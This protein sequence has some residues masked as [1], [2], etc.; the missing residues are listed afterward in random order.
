MTVQLPA[1]LIGNAEVAASSANLGPGFDSLGLA[2]GLYDQIVVETTDV[3]LIVEVEGQGAGQVPTSPEH[4]VV[5][6][7]HRGLE[8]AGFR[9]AGLV[10]RCR[11]NIPHSRGLGS[12]AAAVVGGLAIANALVAQVDTEPLTDA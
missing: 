10:V 5:S 12:S 7:I 2:L 11:N 4:L 3:G 8:A 1:G 9:A 6:A